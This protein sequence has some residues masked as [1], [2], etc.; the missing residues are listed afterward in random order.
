[1]GLEADVRSLRKARIANGGENVP[2]QL[3]GIT[4]EGIR[5]VLKEIDRD[6]IAK[7]SNSGY[8]LSNEFVEIL[9]DDNTMARVW[10]I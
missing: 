5:E 10:V 6:P 1:M 3:Q 4:K 9:K 2:A 7:S 8:R